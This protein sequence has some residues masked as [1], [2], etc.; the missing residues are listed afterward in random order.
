[1]VKPRDCAVDEC[2]SGFPYHDECALVASGCCAREM[3]AALA[4]S[5]DGC[6][7]P[8]DLR[9]GGNPFVNALEAAGLARVREP[10]TYPVRPA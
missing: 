5:P 2:A 7:F 8:L 9:P 3:L 6:H 4:K 10:L 1:M